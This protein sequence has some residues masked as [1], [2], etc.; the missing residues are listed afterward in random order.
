LEE[1]AGALAVFDALR[2]EIEAKF[3]RSGNPAHPRRDG[4][5]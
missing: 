4:S 5:A 1:G 3:E 2:A